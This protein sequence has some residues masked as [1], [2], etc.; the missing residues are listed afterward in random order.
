M[1]VAHEDDD[2]AVLRGAG[3]IGVPEHVAGAVD[4]GALAVPHA[5][6][7]VETAFAAHFRLLGAPQC[8]RREILVE[9]RGDDDVARGEELVGAQELLIDAA[10]RRAAVAGDVAAGIEPRLA[11]ALMLHERRP[12][13]RLGSRHEHP[14]DAEIV[15]VVDRDGVDRHGAFRAEAMAGER[16]AFSDIRPAHDSTGTCLGAPEAIGLLQ[17]AGSGRPFRR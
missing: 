9:A 1:V 14:V 6:H 12:D 7:P 2:A 16:T 10:Q 3:E 11:V 15:F 5:E 8:G 13:Q 4:A 17:G